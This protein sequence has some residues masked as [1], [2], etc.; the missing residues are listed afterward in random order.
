MSDTASHFEYRF[1]WRWLLPL[2]PGQTI[3]LAGFDEQERAFWRDALTPAARVEA[4]GPPQGWIIDAERASVH[5]A[6]MRSMI[7]GAQWVAVVGPQAS[8]QQ[9][10]RSL[11]GGLSHIREYGLLPEENPRVVIPLGSARHTRAALHLYR[12]EFSRDRLSVALVRMFTRVVGSGLLRRRVVL[13][14]A[15]PGGA[16]PMSQAAAKLAADGN[17]PFTD[18]AI[19]LGSPG[20]Q[21]ITAVLPLHKA[22]PQC[23]VKNAAM[24]EARERLK[25]EAEAL[26]RLSHS[27]CAPAIPRYKGLL[28]HAKALHLFQEY[29]SPR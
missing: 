5:P 4:A 16:A 28:E 24:P 22:R 9:W 13:I 7:A 25:N 20:A 18:F 17:K 26:Q 8:V 2:E 3:S 10:R 14:A 23:L 15:R 12:P 29:R 27:P 1:G 19:Q 21:C 6:S 11:A